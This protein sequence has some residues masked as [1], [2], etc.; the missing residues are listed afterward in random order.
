[1]KNGKGKLSATKKQLQRPKQMGF[2]VGSGLV[3]SD[4]DR[5]QEFRKAFKQARRVMGDAGTFSFQ[6]GEEKPKTYTTKYKEEVSTPLGYKQ[7]RGPLQKAGY[8]KNATTP[9]KLDQ[10]PE[11]G[12]TVTGDAS[13]I[14]GKTTM[15]ESEKKREELK[16]RVEA[17][18]IRLANEKMERQMKTEAIKAEIAKRRIA[19]EQDKRR[20]EGKDYIDPSGKVVRRS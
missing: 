4:A 14:G 5:K 2:H 16:K 19:R 12:V 6:I 7:S 3:K 1:M 8:D 13:K 17:R 18:K 20:R 15:T 10:D 11:E 9:F